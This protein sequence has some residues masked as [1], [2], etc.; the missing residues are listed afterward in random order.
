[1]KH[2][3]YLNMLLEQLMSPFKT[4]F[5]LLWPSESFQ[6]WLLPSS[7]MEGAAFRVALERTARS[8]RGV[9]LSGGGTHGPAPSENQPV[10]S[11]SQTPLICEEARGVRRA[12][13]QD[14]GHAP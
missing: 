2:K 6:S 12:E 5:S 4:K 14:G 11:L 1:M 7:A 10:L 13:R 3:L 9:L 8:R